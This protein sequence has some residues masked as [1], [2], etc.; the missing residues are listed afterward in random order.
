MK[1][2]FMRTQRKEELNLS[3]KKLREEEE[4]GRMGT[5]VR[6]QHM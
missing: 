6:E 2:R 4:S 3:G 5:P 1:Q